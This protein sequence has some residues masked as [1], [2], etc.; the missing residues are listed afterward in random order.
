MRRRTGNLQGQRG[1]IPEEERAEDPADRLER[2]ELAARVAELGHR[3]ND[4]LLVVERNNQGTAVLVHLVDL[5]KYPE[6]YCENSEAGMVTTALT[7]PKMLE[8]L[9]VTVAREAA[10]FS[11]E[12][13]LQECR[14]FVRHENG[15]PSAA[16]GAHDDCV[17]SMAFAQWARWE[18]AA[19]RGMTPQWASVSI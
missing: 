10:L 7:R 19:K 12:R 3:Y 14:A 11:G 6:I 1:P 4:A 13:L 9:A 17:M 16:S 8:W 2:G 15:S 18:Q 5:L